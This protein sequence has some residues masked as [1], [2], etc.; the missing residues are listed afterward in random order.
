MSQHM[1]VSHV[2]QT[3][4][5]HCGVFVPLHAIVSTCI[6]CNWLNQQNSKQKIAQQ[7]WHEKYQF[8]IGK[9]QSYFQIS[10]ILTFRTR[11]TETR[12][13]GAYH[14]HIAVEVLSPYSTTMFLLSQ[15]FANT[16]THNAIQCFSPSPLA[17][18]LISLLPSSMLPLMLIN[19]NKNTC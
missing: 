14:L 12:S 18:L 17:S 1:K 10:Q 9:L 19:V 6:P 3:A 5:P 11:N 4:C 7:S 13:Q 2:R 8:F 16:I 15:H